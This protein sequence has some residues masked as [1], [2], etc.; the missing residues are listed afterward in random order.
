MTTTQT[1]RT[2][3]SSRLRQAEIA[4]LARVHLWVTGEIHLRVADFGR[5]ARAILLRRAGEDGL[6]EDGAIGFQ[7]QTEILRAWGDCQSDLE[8]Y[9]LAGLKQAALLPFAL[10]AEEHNRIVRSANQRLQERAG[11]LPSVFPAWV[12][13]QFRLLIGAAQDRSVDGLVLSARIWQIDRLVREEINLRI[14]EAITKKQD[15]W[16]LAKDLEQYLGA[17]QDCPRWTSSRLYGL[18]KKDIADGDLFGLVNGNSCDGQGVAY[19]ALRVARTEIQR[20]HA[21]ATDMQL[22]SSPWVLKERVIRSDGGVTCDICDPVTAGGEGGEGVYP[23]GTIVLP[24][25]PNC[26]CYKVALTMSDDEFIDRLRGWQEGSETWTE[27]DAY[28]ANITGG[29]GVDLSTETNLL[30]T[31]IFGNEKELEKAMKI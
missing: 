24:L 5:Q 26:M 17:N 21:A 2:I 16:S 25:H 22:A 28:S 11:G 31:W 29:A 10:M 6:L 3:P 9:I 14:V 13:Q 23:V 7:A 8:R 1:I 30:N 18:S 12:E 19:K 4:G 15:A 20:V 27:M